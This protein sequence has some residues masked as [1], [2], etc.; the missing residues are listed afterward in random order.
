MKMPK[1]YKEKKNYAHLVN[2]YEDDMLPPLL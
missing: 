1:T 2:L